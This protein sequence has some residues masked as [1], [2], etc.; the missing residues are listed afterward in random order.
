MTKDE[1]VEAF[2]D[3]YQNAMQ[4][5]KDLESADEISKMLDQLDRAERLEAI[6]EISR[7]VGDDYEQTS[8]SAR[9]AFDWNLAL[10][11]LGRLPCK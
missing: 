3:L 6:S 2:T 7:L 1:V 5:E 4:R 9:E 11:L 8:G 10:L